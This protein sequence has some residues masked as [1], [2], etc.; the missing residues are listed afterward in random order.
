[1]IKGIGFDATCSLVALDENGS[2]VTVS[3]SGKHLGQHI[4][5]GDKLLTYNTHKICLQGDDEYNIILWMDHRA[6]KQANYINSKNHKIL[7]Y[8]GGKVSLEMETPKMLWLKQ[9]LPN[10]WRRAK[11]LFDLPDFLTWKATGAESRYCSYLFEMLLIML[12]PIGF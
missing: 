9:N 10:S 11:L 12:I 8:V 4:F 2:P 3:P 5:N 1:M 6:E 7:K